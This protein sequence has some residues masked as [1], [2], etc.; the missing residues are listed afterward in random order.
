[1]SMSSSESLLRWFIGS[2]D[3]T[4]KDFL[5]W[6]KGEDPLSLEAIGSAPM[7]LGDMEAL[8]PELV[9]SLLN[10]IRDESTLILEKSQSVCQTPSKGNHP[11]KY[12]YHS[13]VKK[14]TPLTLEDQPRLL[15]E[16]SHARRSLEGLSSGNKKPHGR[17]LSNEVQL[18][19]LIVK[20]KT[21]K[22]RKK[23][24]LISQDV[25]EFNNPAF[26]SSPTKETTPLT[27]TPSP[28]SPLTLKTP[29]KANSVIKCPTLDPSPDNVLFQT[30]L[31]KLIQLYS[32]CL[33][34]NLVPNIL[35][36]LY[37]IL[38]LLTVRETEK[39]TKKAIASS[40]YLHSVHNCVY[41]ATQ[42][43]SLQWERLLQF[44][45]RVTLRLLLDNQ[46]LDIFVPQLK[47]KLTIIYEQ[48]R[49]KNNHNHS[50]SQTTFGDGSIQSVRFQSE[51][52]NRANFPTTQSFQYFRKQRDLFY[53]IL[54]ESEAD[55]RSSSLKTPDTKKKIKVKVETLL[56]SS[57][58]VN[59]IHL[60]RLFQ[61]QLVGT[62]FSFLINGSSSTT[63][64]PALDTLDE[65]Q[66]LKSIDPIKY[67][68]L[69]SRFTTPSM[70][71]G[72]CPKP[73]FIGPQEFFRDFISSCNNHQFIEH[74]KT[75]LVGTMIE[76][77]DYS[78]TLL[79][80]NEN[81]SGN[82]W[83]LEEEI[84]ETV[85]TLKILA[86]YL[87]YIE[88]I[89]YVCSSENIPDTLVASQISL[90]KNVTP[91]LDL[92]QILRQSLQ[93]ERLVVTL[94]WMVEY[95]SMI[96]PISV[97]LPYYQELFSMLV[98]IY[99][100]VLL[101]KKN[102]GDGNR[103]SFNTM[104]NF[105]LCLSLGWLFE[106]PSFPRELLVDSKE[107]KT[108]KPATH[109]IEKK[110]VR[111]PS[112]YEI[113]LDNTPCVTQNL[114]YTSC[115]YLSE[116]KSILSQ[117]LSKDPVKVETLNSTPPV[118]S[119]PRIMP[120][121]ILSSAE[122]IKQPISQ[123]SSLQVEMEE[124][125]FHN[126]PASLRKTIEFIA[127]R[128]ASNCVKT[129]RSVLIGQERKKASKAIK[130]RIDKEEIDNSSPSSLKNKLLVEVENIARESCGKVRSIGP[131][132]I[133]ERMKESISLSLKSLLA[134]DTSQV[135]FNTSIKITERKTLEIACQWIEDHVTL[136]YFIKDYQQ[137]FN[138][139]LRLNAQK[140]E[141]EE[142]VPLPIVISS[143]VQEIKKVISDDSEEQSIHDD[144]NLHPSK[145]LIRLKEDL[146]LMLLTNNPLFFTEESVINV[147]KNIKICLTNSREMISTLGVLG[148][149]N[150][151]VDWIMS[152]ITFSPDC[153][154]SNVFD[155]LMEVW[156]QHL[157]I[158]SQ[159]MT[160][161]C[162]RN[163]VLLG[164]STQPFL[165]WQRLERLLYSL[166]KSKI[167]IPLALEDQ[168]IQLLKQEWPE[169]I[170]KK[171]A[172]SLR[173]VVLF[174]KDS[175]LHSR[176]NDDEIEFV[177]L[178]EWIVWYCSSAE[179]YTPD[180]QEFPELG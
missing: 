36:E 127:E 122:K 173:G 67:Q 124:N 62:C 175:N 106:N 18:S 126:Q 145:L 46:R 125:F 22:S 165:T 42:V 50:M 109:T 113:S 79:D 102:C 142:T 70:F 30:Q 27:H 148:F 26:G 5:S 100:T 7:T 75:H 119:S 25:S 83:Q 132:W 61:C 160:I 123:R 167:L 3:V 95:C 1:M 13:P 45:D 10:F 90:R 76:L 96:D 180:K 87:G 171:F 152:L 177:Q 39:S 88:S 121:A 58:P 115:P 163:M 118:T 150:L 59:L 38:E 17:R 94:P 49:E 140:S 110:R 162:P 16:K 33:D 136:R 19:D 8:K 82:V 35:V 43:L 141:N 37:L 93:E 114:L 34:E 77:N 139:S 159:I 81:S 179:D 149:E 74:L 54:R 101:P 117:F 72:P 51:T 172:S 120:T 143:G 103:R 174:W 128:V 85:T 154:T 69:Q 14:V 151:T 55:E 57:H 104:N 21:P 29:Q 116:L 31:D 15:P 73:E 155:H 78:F 97:H 99:R 71:G 158:Q 24:D 92:V 84:F 146:K 156:T 2:K 147:L 130:E 164:Q 169:A 12:D 112:K 135:V 133:S 108:I 89:P 66:E 134:E 144:I 20:K 129:L 4:F 105:F 48:K 63:D 170:L 166:L 157:F 131:D 111:H 178:M 44:C 68:R 53:E 168:C 23:I 176:S 6:Y 28:A 153:L 64:E 138:H 32:F 47:P 91:A 161:L 65:M 56:A 107:M 60:A 52:D 86:K 98:N 41:F 137:E 80:K 9:L 11:S 40:N